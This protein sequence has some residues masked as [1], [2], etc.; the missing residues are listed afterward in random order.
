M[1]T[2]VVSDYFRPQILSS[3]VVLSNEVV[4]RRRLRPCVEKAP[5]QWVFCS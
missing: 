5:K 1:G 2:D 3:K 4:N